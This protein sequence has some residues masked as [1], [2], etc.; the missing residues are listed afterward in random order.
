MKGKFK[1][2]WEVE[3]WAESP[4]EAAKAAWEYMKNP[5]NIAGLFTV[6]DDDHSLRIDLHQRLTAREH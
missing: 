3:V 6:S 4:E 5:D 2:V 1:V